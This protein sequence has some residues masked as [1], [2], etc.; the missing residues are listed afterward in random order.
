MVLNYSLISKF[1]Y[2][3]RDLDICEFIEAR[4]A[5]K[6][7]TGRYIVNVFDQKSLIST[8]EFELK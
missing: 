1:N 2:E 5:D 7:G 6:F 3:A 4:G 8:A